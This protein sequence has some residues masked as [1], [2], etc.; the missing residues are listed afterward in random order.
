MSFQCHKLYLLSIV[1]YPVASDYLRVLSF[2]ILS[3]FVP[4]TLLSQLSYQVF[5]Y[6]KMIFISMLADGNP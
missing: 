5:P 4:C 6:I 3:C 1:V 2:V